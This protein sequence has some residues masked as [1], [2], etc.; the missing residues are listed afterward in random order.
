MIGNLDTFSGALAR[1]SD[2]LDRIVAGLERMTGGAAAKARL[3]SYDLSVPRSRDYGKAIA[4]AARCPRSDRSCCIGQRAYPDRIGKRR[5]C[6]RARRA[7]ER[8]AAQAVAGEN[9]SQPG[10]CRKICRR[11]PSAGR[12]HD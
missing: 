5:L 6:E 7:M 1:N 8:Y 10:G 12:P 3:V 4:G 2:R 9:S 11:E